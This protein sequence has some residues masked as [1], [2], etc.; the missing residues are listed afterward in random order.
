MLLLLLPDVLAHGATYYTSRISA[1]EDGHVWA[2]VDGWGVLHSTD[3]V[4]WDWICEEGLGVT[5]VYDLQALEGG[6]LL[7]GTSEGLHRFGASCGTESLAGLPE[8]AQVGE[9]QQVGSQ[10]FAAVAAPSEAGVWACDQTTCRPTSLVGPAG[11]RL[12]AK[13]LLADEKNLWATVVHEDD[14]ASELYVS[15]NGSWELRSAWP[16]GSLDLRLLHVEG[17][18]VLAWAQPRSSSV[19]PALYLSTDGGRSFHSTLETGGWQDPIPGLAVVG[20]QI[21][22]SSYLGRTWRSTDGGEN[23]KEVSSDAPLLRCWT[24]V[25]DEVWVCTDHFA[26]GFDVGRTRDGKSWE[27]LACMEQAEL[28]PCTEDTCATLY[29]T[30]SSYGGTARGIC[31]QQED[32]GEK[33]EKSCGCTGDAAAL[34]LPLLLSLRRRRTGSTG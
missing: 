3:G 23:W 21:F 9:L 8:L 7:V 25:G 15:I 33:P 20:E 31:G 4:T 16:D 2:L 5:A 1:S 24:K 27:A 18:R 30:F 12:F 17:D 6:G 22:L 13:S 32:S 14:L 10:I 26:D 34:W 29:D 28:A 19:V 11:S